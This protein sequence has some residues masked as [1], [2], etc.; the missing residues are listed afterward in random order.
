MD[1]G[2]VK[3]F[4]KKQPTVADVLAALKR[5]SGDQKTMADISAKARAYFGT[6]W[7]FNLEMYVNSMPAADK[8]FYAPLVSNM[9]VFDRSLSLWLS[10]TRIV[11][12]TGSL[13][14]DVMKSMPEYEKYLP[15][16]GIEGVRLLERFKKKLGMD[17]TTA[18]PPRPAVSEPTSA[19]EEVDVSANSVSGKIL[20]KVSRDDLQE[21][22]FTKALS[23]DGETE[24]IDQSGP[25][26]DSKVQSE[27]RPEPSEVV[28]EEHSPLTEPGD[29]IPPAP[30]AD[31][32]WEIG[33]FLRVH[34]FLSASREVMSSIVVE[35]K[36]KLLEDYP[37]YGFI[38]DAIRYM[39]SA[40][41]KILAEKSDVKIG[42][43]F[44]GGRKE[45]ESLMEF[46]KSEE[47][48]QIADPAAVRGGD[49]DEATL[50]YVRVN[51]GGA[52]KPK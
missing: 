22:V 26:L 27:P 6:D 34:S 11:K 46:Y 50:G 24:P 28:P 31:K 23:K 3:N 37:H 19:P 39:I 38:L 15:K 35:G 9:L 44:K 30:A 16:F 52:K 14:P 4:F 41:K 5:F 36:Y 2:F 48:A 32:D 1:F 12:G 42:E 13:S 25:G 29:M 51:K 40:G 43:Y 49:D 21:G 47:A 33:N 20:K 18:I 17:A 45:L 7:R 10:A 8:E